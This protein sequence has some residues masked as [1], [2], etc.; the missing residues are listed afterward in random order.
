LLRNSAKL[1]N[2]GYEIEL[3]IDVIRGKDFR[4]NVGLNGTTYKT[5]LLEIP[6]TVKSAALGGK[7]TAPIDGWGIASGGATSSGQVMY[8]RGEGMDYYN[9]YLYKYAGVDQNTGLPLFNHTVTQKDLDAG[10]FEGSKVGSIV[11]TT[12]F[13]LADRYGM[14]SALP[15]WI[16]GFTTT[17]QYKNFDF[18][19]ILAYQLGGKFL[20]VEYGNNLYRSG[21]IG[22]ALSAELIGNTWTPEN[23]DAK[24]PM[25]LYDDNNFT[26]GATIGS[27]AYSDM[28]LFSSSYLNIKNLTLGYNFG[29]NIAQKILAKS[30]RL[31]ASADNIAMFT[32]HSGI[33][34]RMSLVGGME[35]GAAVY[36]PM[37]TVSVGLNVN[38]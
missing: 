32:S 18:M 27:W 37:S 16:G 6:S 5:T 19:A 14:G 13:K 10:M 38:F 8:L 33:D 3:N 9:L 24:F 35:V 11:S 28:A 4:W 21:N 12:N 15:K 20:S 7:Y 2:R 30:I 25:A 29:S 34:P 1:R 31:Y 26:A 36:L 17:L 23:R 22:N